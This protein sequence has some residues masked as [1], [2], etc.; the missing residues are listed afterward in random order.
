[1]VDVAAATATN[2]QPP[3]KLKGQENVTLSFKYTSVHFLST[4][5][6][7]K[8]ATSDFVPA[9]YLS[10]A[11]SCYITLNSCCLPSL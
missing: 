9:V 1:M 2:F 6:A 10:E 4:G 3:I 7:I 8:M 11:Q 5:A